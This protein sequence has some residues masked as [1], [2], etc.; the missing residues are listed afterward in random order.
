MGARKAAV[1][2]L[3]LGLVGLGCSDS[4]PRT[5]HVHRWCAHG[6]EENG[7]AWL[8]LSVLP[9]TSCHG[10]SDGDEQQI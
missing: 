2:P 4:V 6:H 3:S 7:G 1:G 5:V 9:P 10:G 8:R